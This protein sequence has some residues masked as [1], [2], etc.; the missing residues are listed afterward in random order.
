MNNLQKN[1]SSKKISRVFL[2]N[3]KQILNIYFL[4]FSVLIGAVSAFGALAFRGLIH[5]FQ[6][7]F[8]GAGEI[9]FLAAVMSCPWWVIL[10]VP[11]CGAVLGGFIIVYIVPE[12][13]GTGVPEVILS[14][15]DQQSRIRGRVTFF[16]ALA[17]GLFIGAGASVGREGP[18]V[19]IGSSVG[20]S[21][22]QA[23]KLTPMHRRVCLACGAAAGISATFN[24]PITGALFAVEIILLDLEVMYLVHVITASVTGSVISRLFLG[25]LPYLG[26]AVFSMQSYAELLVYLVL[27]VAAGGLG[28]LFIRLL[29]AA[30]TFFAKIPVP[31]WLTPAI[32]GLILGIFGLYYPELLGVG[33][34]TVEEALFTE[35]AL[36]YVFILLCMKMILT[37]I[38]IGSGM[39]GGIFAPSLV[40]GSL[41]GAATA[42]VI[43]L[44]VPGMELIPT[45]YALA[46]MGAFVAGTTFAPITAIFTIFELT[47]TEEIILPLMVSCISSVMIG[48]TLFGYS[49]Y[50]MKLLRK[51]VNLIRGRDVAVLRQIPVSE[52]MVEEF[53]TLD[54]K[55]DMMTVIRKMNKTAFPHFVVVNEENRLAGVLS[56]RDVQ[57]VMTDLELLTD[58]VITADIMVRNVITISPQD[59]LLN[60]LFLFEAHHISFL[61]VTDPDDNTKVIAILRRD[62]MLKAYREKVFSGHILSARKR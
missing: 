41:L 4:F 14:V 53:E 62:D 5:F 52:E 18:I 12:A 7:L 30:D 6:W 16:K 29:Y 22:A 28:I 49:V 33:Y 20:S 46:G 31:G 61:P 57:K 47:Y 1:F 48:R 11:V 9:S 24:A 42:Q 23:L 50:E 3:R 56:P 45:N 19:Q 37:C 55:A 13:R 10:V 27:G 40:L 51:N 36:S 60:A 21:L 43:N 32:A 58:L 34:G 38:C 54:V 26:H 44:A 59:N 15:A 25:D 2:L 35:L 8:W 17:T 39:S